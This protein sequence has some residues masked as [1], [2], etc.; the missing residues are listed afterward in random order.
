MLK[1]QKALTEPEPKKDFYTFI[2]IILEIK[3]NQKNRIIHL[4]LN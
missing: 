4:I 2:K 1:M 3:F